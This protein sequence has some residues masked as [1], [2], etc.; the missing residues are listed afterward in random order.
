MQASGKECLKSTIYESTLSTAPRSP[1]PNGEGKLVAASPQYK[2]GDVRR[3]LDRRFSSYRQPSCGE[4]ASQ[5]RI[6]HQWHA[7]EREGVSQIDDL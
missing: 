2:S 1:F 6:G 3:S 7:S 4:D 5:G